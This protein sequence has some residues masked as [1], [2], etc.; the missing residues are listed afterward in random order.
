MQPLRYSNPKLKNPMKTC[1]YLA[2][3]CRCAMLVQSS[4][5]QG[6]NAKM[7]RIVPLRNIPGCGIRME[8]MHP[9]DESE[10]PCMSAAVPALTCRLL[11][12]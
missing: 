11:R 5:Q 9:E 12:D 2:V 3:R 10:T 1:R 7:C 8:L 6:Q 4:H